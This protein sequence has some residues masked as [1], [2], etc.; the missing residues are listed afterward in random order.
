[1]AEESDAEEREESRPGWKVKRVAAKVRA[2]QEPR[3]RL[4]QLEPSEAEHEML[5]RMA[6]YLEAKAEAGASCDD[7]AERVVEALAAARDAAVAKVAARMSEAESALHELQQQGHGDLED[8]HQKVQQLEHTLRSLQQQ[9]QQHPQE[10][11]SQTAQG[12]D[13][14]PPLSAD[15]LATKVEEQAQLLDEAV[16][17]KRQL[18]SEL[19]SEQEARSAAEQRA[20][21]AEAELSA[22]SANK[23]SGAEGEPGELQALRAQLEDERKQKDEALSKL[24]EFGG[25]FESLEKERNEATNILEEADRT[26]S[27]LERERESVSKLKQELL[28]AQ[29]RQ[30]QDRATDQ[31]STKGETT[32]T[33]HSVSE[34]VDRH[35]QEQSKA[36]SLILKI[37]SSSHDLSSTVLQQLIEPLEIAIKEKDAMAQDVQALGQRALQADYAAALDSRLKEA[38][39]DMASIV[40]GLSSAIGA[41]DE[42]LDA[43]QLLERV[44]STRA[45]NERLSQ[46]LEKCD[47]HGD[48]GAAQQDRPEASEEQAPHHGHRERE[49]AALADAHSGY[50][51][52][53]KERIHELETEL[54]RERPPKG[55]SSSEAAGNV[56][57]QL[58]EL[59]RCYEQLKHSFSQH[60]VNQR[61]LQNFILQQRLNTPAILN[62]ADE[63]ATDGDNDGVDVAHA[64][65][66]TPEVESRIT[67]DHASA[68]EHLSSEGVCRNETAESRAQRPPPRGK[69]LHNEY[70]KRKQ[71]RRGDEC[72]RKRV[73]SPSSAR[74]S[75]GTIDEVSERRGDR[76]DAVHLVVPHSEETEIPTRSPSV[77]RRKSAQ[78]APVNRRADRGQKSHIRGTLQPSAGGGTPRFCKRPK[79]DERV[80]CDAHEEEIPVQ[81]KDKQKKSG[82]RQ[83]AK[84]YAFRPRSS[85]A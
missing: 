56:E 53:L 76:G 34:N 30:Q 42:E 43:R 22:P 84:I 10:P 11:P 33:Q 45:Q 62:A 17:R 37:L 73:S 20:S 80:S 49:E 24:E 63:A 52:S 2:L 48:Q 83:Q 68:D 36:L 51:A 85:L 55:T 81:Q 54:D 41:E 40:Q 26:R 74:G 7:V 25:A 75:V 66:G 8:T 6:Q 50:V 9:H 39:E 47:E 59:R 1:M 19:A 77:G 46:M 65:S 57:S 23:R 18:E 69:R 15:A 67:C 60:C 31:A 82:K 72:R 21:D 64:V 71:Q 61:R 13:P 3:E 32:S 4:E 16:S 44:R 58:N 27:E 28:E 78:A 5:E 70:R 38:K 35:L 14:S 29:Q 12:N 79:C